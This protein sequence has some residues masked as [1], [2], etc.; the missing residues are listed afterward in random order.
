M[1]NNT[2]TS[3][4]YEKEKDIINDVKNFM[5]WGCYENITIEQFKY[6]EK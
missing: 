6:T 5:K 3:K 1:T 4:T 2:T